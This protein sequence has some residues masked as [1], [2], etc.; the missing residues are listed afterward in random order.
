MNA[1]LFRLL[2][3]VIRLGSV[4]AIDP[5]QMPPRVRIDSGDLTTDWLPWVTLRAGQVRTWHPP[6]VGERVMVLAPGGNL[7]NG[8]A[9]PA[10]FCEELPPPTNELHKSVTLY[11]DG[12]R[13]EY[14]YQAKALKAQLPGTA[15]LTCQGNVSV[16]THGAVNVTAQGPVD[17]SAKAPVTVTAPAGVTITGPVTINGTLNVTGNVTSSADVQASG[18]SLTQHIHPGVHG[19]TGAPQ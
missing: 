2:N 11:P 12:A 9:L 7:A 18:I 17:I 1:E 3:N 14:D 5:T 13:I 16:N 10:L 15:E 6:S 8:V 19:P 4:A